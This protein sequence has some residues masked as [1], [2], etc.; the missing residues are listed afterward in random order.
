MFALILHKNK[1]SSDKSALLTHKYLSNKLFTNNDLDKNHEDSF[2]KNNIYVVAKGFCEKRKNINLSEY[3]YNQINSSSNKYPKLEF[4]YISYNEKKDIITAAIDRFGAQ[5]IYYFNSDKILIISNKNKFIKDYLKLSELDKSW[6]YN[7]L[8]GLL[9]DKTTTSIK[10]IKKLPPA[11]YLE[12]KNKQLEIKQYWKLEKQDLGNLSLNDYIVNFKYL[13]TESVKN[14][15]QDNLGAELSG[16]LDSSGIVGISSKF[17]ANIYTYSHSLPD[18]LL[19]KFFPYKDEREFC[20]LVTRYNDISDKNR[21]IQCNNASIFNIQKNEL[22]I[23]G[24][25]TNIAL[26]YFSNELL[27]TAQKDNIKTIFSGFGG[28]EGVSNQGSFMI[29][30]WARNFNLYQLVK[31]KKNFIKHI[32]QVYSK[33]YKTHLY[34][35]DNSLLNK[36]F[37]EENSFIN[38]QKK[39]NYRTLSDFIHYRLSGNYLPNR[40]EQF[41]QTAMYRG[42]NYSFPLLDYKLVEFYY[43][44]P[45]KYKFYKAQKRYLFKEAI[46]DFAPKEV[47]TRNDK[48]GATVPNVLHRFMI[49][50]DEIYDYL[51]SSKNG[52]A[53]EYINIK[54]MISRMEL[55]KQLYQGNRIRANQHIFFNALMIVIYL[56]ED[57]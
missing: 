50:Y 43:S 24:M 20:N 29:Y 57:Y 39:L 22:K 45:D 14:R 56:N 52:K 31:N 26:T 36:D 38:N 1:K 17:K 9:S 3:I 12:F 19:G 51:Q 30:Q 41:Q 40:M 18:N 49:D 8:T 37:S 35:H 15:I 13:L 54:E 48:T 47:Y 55:I 6:M 28:D 44:I 33:N 42:I 34:N 7:S 5:P 25:P 32:I 27:N 16:G 23:L 4:S 2:Y 53:S 10:G 21:K 46:K 11:H